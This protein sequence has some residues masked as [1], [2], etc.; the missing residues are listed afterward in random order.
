[1]CFRRI[2][3]FIVTE[4]YRPGCHEVAWLF[5]NLV[6]LIIAVFVPPI[7]AVGGQELTDVHPSAMRYVIE[8]IYTCVCA[9]APGGCR[10]AVAAIAINAIY[11]LFVYITWKGKSS[12][13]R[14]RIPWL[15]TAA[16][17]V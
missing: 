15:D 13:P 8:A 7:T 16:T 14:G 9:Q 4:L 6:I 17:C 3:S 5:D 11:P 2:D 12:T 10:F 1:M